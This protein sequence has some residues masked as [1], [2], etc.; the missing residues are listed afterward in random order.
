MSHADKAGLLDMSNFI[1][2]MWSV[3]TKEERKAF[4]VLCLNALESIGVRIPTGWSSS[5]VNFLALS[6]HTTGMQA[7][8]L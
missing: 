4:Q 5:S 1:C 6:I 3:K 7:K 8:S 2:E